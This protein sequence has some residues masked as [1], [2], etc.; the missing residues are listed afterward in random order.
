MK[1]TDFLKTMR[2]LLSCVTL[3]CLLGATSAFAASRVMYV[4][5]ENGYDLNV[6]QSDET[7][8]RRLGTLANG[9]SVSV[10]SRS[11]DWYKI[12]YGKREGYV[13]AEFLTSSASGIASNGSDSA[14]RKVSRTMYVRTR[15][16]GKLNLR[17]EARKSSRSLGMYANGTAVKVTSLSARW[18]K[19]RAEGQEG[20]MMLSYLTDQEPENAQGKNYDAYV[21]QKSA[22]LYAEADARS[23]KILTI[24]G[25]T[26]VRVYDRNTTWSQVTVHG[27]LGFV[28]TAALTTERPD[29]VLKNATIVNPNGASYVNLRSTPGIKG[30]ANVLNCIRVGRTV[31][32]MG[33]VRSWYKI[34]SG[35]DAGYVHSS[36]LSLE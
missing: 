10:L 11:G 31:Q 6:R 22:A 29:L 32:I 12:Q 9:S 23:Q 25:G 7:G 28:K 2:I 30:D 5:T 15:N 33:K 35:G 18:A 1:H 16:K 17:E 4:H 24:P 8:A 3:L 27:R 20:Y 26:T 19:V 13:K 14:W 34:L 36:F 21:R